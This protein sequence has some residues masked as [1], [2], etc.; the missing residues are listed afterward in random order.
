MS[1]LKS[2]KITQIIQITFL[3]LICILFVLPLV[4]LLNN[5]FYNLFNIFNSLE[6]N[7]INRMLIYLVM[8][9]MMFIKLLLIKSN[10][11]LRIKKLSLFFSINLFKFFLLYYIK[12]NELE[13]FFCYIYQLKCFGKVFDIEYTIGFDNLAFIFIFLTTFLISVCLLISWENIYYNTKKFFLLFLVLELL[14]IQVFCSLDLILFYITFESILIPMY[15]LIGCWGAR[16]RRLH[17]AYNFFLFTLAGSLFMLA[18]LIFCHSTSG[19]T[20]YGE[21]LE[22]TF[23][24]YR[25]MIIWLCFFIGFAVKI[26]MMPVHI[27]LPEAHVESITGGSVALAGILLKLGTFGMLRFLLPLFKFSSYYFSPL[28]Y[29]ISFLSMLY[30]SLTTLRQI[31]LKK[32]IAYSS[33][34]H[35]NYLIIGLFSFNVEGVLGSILLMVAHG[36]VSGGLFVC[37][38]ILYDRYH[39]RLLKPYGGLNYYMPIFSIFFLL[40]T[41]ANISFPGSFNFLGEF[42]V[43]LGIF[44]QNISFGLVIMFTMIL[45]TCYS[46]WLYNKVFSGLVISTSYLYKINGSLIKTFNIKRLFL[47]NFSDLNLREIVSLFILIVPTIFLGIEPSFFFNIAYSDVES[48]LIFFL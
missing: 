12:Y 7:I 1:I 25:E 20:N 2:K 48:I 35:M 22:Y 27:W 17:A 10:D 21:L 33:I 6:F 5:G 44:R 15:F 43:L 40:F 24:P 4:C 31:D 23:T 19:T 13:R 34:I 16:E 41:L 11:I 14:L 3:S 18:G 45:S 39:I 28:V 29:L 38:G 30:A 36:F 32:I 8:L 46:F 47:S 37:V 26:P 9:L 42:F